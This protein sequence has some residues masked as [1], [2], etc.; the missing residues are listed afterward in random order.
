MLRP[1]TCRRGA[2]G[3][4]LLSLAASSASAI[5]T[6][7]SNGFNGLNINDHIGATRWY[8]RGYHGSRA[9]IANVEAGHIWKGHD[10]LNAQLA[11]FITAPT[12]LG[13][14]DRHATWVGHILAGQ[15]GGLNPGEHQRGIADAATLWSAA[16]A[17]DWNSAGF[18]FYSTSFNFSTLAYLD[19]YRT[20]TLSGL[21]G[22]RADVVNS[23]WGFLDRTQN[24]QLIRIIDGIARDSG[25]LFVISAGNGG[26]SGDTVQ[27]P[28]SA[29]NT[30]SVG[31][32]A[33]STD[34]DPFM[35]VARFSARGPSAFFDPSVGTIPGV[36]AGVDIVAPGSDFTLARYGGATG[37]NVFGGSVSTAT[38]EYN[39]RMQGT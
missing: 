38:N 23:S 8:S 27:V 32:L 9:I 28:A 13:D 26:P 5:V 21:G 15:L 36:R 35:R 20:A 17:S 6:F 2:L 12:A 29:F 10:T 31:A 25:K 34:P 7:G 1:S 22:I 33:G 39:T 18:G 24:S 16:I 4:A 14:T 37:G 11:A 19:A 3:C 30:L